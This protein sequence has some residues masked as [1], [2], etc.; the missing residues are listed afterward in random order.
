MQEYI[1]F[2]LASNRK[3]MPRP[4]PPRKKNALI[5]VLEKTDRKILKR[6]AG[7]T[8]NKNIAIA[9]ENF[10]N[11]GSLKKIYVLCDNVLA[12]KQK[13][14]SFVYGTCISL[15]V[16][17]LRYSLDTRIRD[18]ASTRK[19]KTRD[20]QNPSQYES[21]L[22]RYVQVI[23]KFRNDKH[24]AYQTITEDAGSNI[25]PEQAST[26]LPHRLAF[27][28][29]G[30][31]KRRLSWKNLGIGNMSIGSLPYNALTI[32]AMMY[33]GRV[34]LWAANP[35][36]YMPF[37]QNAEFIR[38][39]L[40]DLIPSS[41]TGFPSLREHA[42]GIPLTALRFG[43]VFSILVPM[44]CGVAGIVW[45]AVKKLIDL[46]LQ[47]KLDKV[48]GSCCTG[49]A[50]SVDELATRTAELEA[51]I[52]QMSVLRKAMDGLTNSVNSLWDLVPTLA[53]K[54]ELADSEGR[55]GDRIENG[56][57]GVSDDVNARLAA[58]K[59][60]VAEAFDDFRTKNA[61]DMNTTVV[62]FQNKLD[63]LMISVDDQFEKINGK[64]S[65][66][67]T[68]SSKFS[69]E[70]W[71]KVEKKMTAL[72]AKNEELEG[73]VDALI[74][75]V[76]ELPAQV[77]KDLFKKSLGLREMV[78]DHKAKRVRRDV[79]RKNPLSDL[80]RAR[81]YRD[82]RWDDMIRKSSPIISDPSLTIPPPEW[83]LD[84]SPPDQPGQTLITHPFEDN[85]SPATWTE[86]LPHAKKPL[87]EAGESVEP[88][89]KNSFPAVF[90]A[91]KPL[92]EAGLPADRILEK[93]VPKIFHSD[94]KLPSAVYA[95]WSAVQQASNDLWTSGGWST[96]NGNPPSLP[97]EEEKS[98]SVTENSH[99]VIDEQQP[100][101]Q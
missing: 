25:R 49:V 96:S 77:R 98:Q 9:V 13:Y 10:P 66:L 5:G 17:A 78:V 76:N 60:D 55:S 79:E 39:K 80:P 8:I 52:G 81:K 50:K 65:D 97:G 51:S 38:E 83:Y 56:L 40:Y 57:R 99:N 61:Q 29:G 28:L 45:P 27:M 3:K 100:K 42:I 4:P 68:A 71:D 92:Y 94:W 64:L 23:Y 30:E 86:P 26:N 70:W 11:P 7:Q 34:A 19:L 31:G 16:G 75:I 46:F 89:I 62:Q 69:N 6:A 91:K 2:L 36:G 44:V 74:K 35:S 85:Q 72:S 88:V 53:T 63:A 18:F 101:E 41:I 37:P 87:Y 48:G 24:E 21:V 84:Y 43:G 20:I 33:V 95:G 22:R 67:G 47:E 73:S 14:G 93:H 12:G 54:T 15:L 58:S 82:P 1:F 90:Y 32:A 59:K